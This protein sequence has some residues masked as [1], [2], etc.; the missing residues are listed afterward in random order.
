MSLRSVMT[1][2]FLTGCGTM[3]LDLTVSDSGRG[4]GSGNSW[5]VMEPQSG[6][7]FQCVD[8]QGSPA[9]ETAVLTAKGSGQV[10]L[11]D[12]R[13][14]SSN[15]ELVS[16]DLPLPHQLPVNVEYPVDIK[17]SPTQSSEYTGVLEVDVENPEN[18]VDTLQLPLRGRGC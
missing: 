10:V 15:F 16:D 13:L 17:F 1:V 5:L 6:L 3:G 4:R 2:L 8:V 11:I 18:E 14:S 12:I 7:D 9:I